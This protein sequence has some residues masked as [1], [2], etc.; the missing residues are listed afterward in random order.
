MG[1]IDGPEATDMSVDH[2]HEDEEV[3]IIV[4]EVVT[5]DDRPEPHANGRIEAVELIHFHVLR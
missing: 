4:V 5:A 2:G 1:H 3:E